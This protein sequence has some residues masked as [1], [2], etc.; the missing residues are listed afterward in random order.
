MNTTL[1]KVESELAKQRHK[2]SIP[3]Q[4]DTN[5]G[6]FHSLPSSSNELHGE[7]GQARDITA[8]KLVSRCIC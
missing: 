7:K 6:H 8:K 3:R 4:G 1:E 2:E 5:K